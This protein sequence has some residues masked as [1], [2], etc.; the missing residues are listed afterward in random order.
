MRKFKDT[1]GHEWT[2]AITVDAIKRVR[3]MLDVDLLS[4]IEGK[5][6]ERL[7]RDPVLLCDIV[8]VVCKPEADQAGIADEEFGRAMAGDA[9]EHAT[10]AL[11]DDL[12][13]FSPSPKDRANIGRVIKATWDAIDKAQDLV[14]AK[15]DEGI[16]DTVLMEAMRA[17]NQGVPPEQAVEQALANAGDSSGSAPE[18]LAS[19]PAP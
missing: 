8:Y 13:D 15:L 7:Y 17:A 1:N 3:S 4:I 19:I 12:V 10:K 18:S 6:I 9:I 14:G 2:I 5:L 16:L 11:L